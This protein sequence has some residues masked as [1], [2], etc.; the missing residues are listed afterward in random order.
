MF[1]EFG[2]EIEVWGLSLLTVCT[3]TATITILILDGLITSRR[4]PEAGGSLKDDICLMSQSKVGL[5]TTA[6]WSRNEFRIGGGK[7]YWEENIIIIS[8]K[9]NKD[10]IH[11]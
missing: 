7:V 1:F 11:T 5:A 10:R 4:L 6:Q 2:A 8:Y 3:H 9:I